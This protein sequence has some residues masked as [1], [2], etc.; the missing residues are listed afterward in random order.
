MAFF[1]ILIW[2]FITLVI[3]GPVGMVIAKLASS[4]LRIQD[5]KKMIEVI[6]G[7]IPNNIKVDGEI[8]N[9]QKF[10]SKN[11]DGK[12]V[13]VEFGKE[14]KKTSPQ[15][16]NSEKITLLKRLKGMFKKNEN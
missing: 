3:G 8:F 14:S 15:S 1:D 5:E 16:L 4:F 7:R 2:V 11:K 6:N 10:T 12:M 13:V 9:I